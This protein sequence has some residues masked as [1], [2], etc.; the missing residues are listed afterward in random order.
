MSTGQGPTV[1]G[2]DQTEAGFAGTGFAGV[3]AVA[4]IESCCALAQRVLIAEGV[5]SGQLDLI[6]VDAA[7]MAELNEMHMGHEGPTDVL[8]F[9][10]DADEIALMMGDQIAADQPPG[11]GPPLHLG[12]V[13]LCPSVAERQAP[14]H[15][16]SIEAELSLLIIHGV[17]HIL[18]HDHAEPEETMLMQARERLHLAECGFDHP[19]PR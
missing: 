5:T 10:M 13:V 1:E 12:D 3:A 18:G 11:H 6:L 7:D 19:V 2:F 4:D 15:C 9:P 14:D 8:S 17:L 16:G